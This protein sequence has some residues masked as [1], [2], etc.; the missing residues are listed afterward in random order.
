MTWIPS[1]AF[2]SIHRQQEE[3]ARDVGAGPIKTFL[4]VTFPLAMPGIAVAS[5]FTF[6]NSLEEAQGTMVVG[7]PRFR[8]MPIEMYGVILDFPATAGAVFAIILIIPTIL[9]LFGLRK[10]IGP[11][12]LAK[13]F[14]MK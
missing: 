2:R 11:E 8:T 12:A 3:A 13:G 7:L 4:S 10:F 1:S 9:L 6:L 14:K 5:I